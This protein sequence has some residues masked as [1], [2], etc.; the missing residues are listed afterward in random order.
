MV[1]VEVVVKGNLIHA[2]MKMMMKRTMMKMMM[3]KMADRTIVV[4]WM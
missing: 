2:M 1:V 3:V 4:A